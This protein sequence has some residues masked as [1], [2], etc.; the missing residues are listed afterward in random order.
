M[1]FTE[2]GFEFWFIYEIAIPCF[3]LLPH[4]LLAALGPW[5][6]RTP[7]SRPPGQATR[8]ALD[9]IRP[10]S[11]RFPESAPSWRHKSST[12]ALAMLPASHAG[13]TP[14]ATATSSPAPP[15][16]DSP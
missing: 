3:S 8:R 9:Q 10:R 11:P 6:G 16:V 7:A 14:F 5:P 15:P 12:R 1:E 13:R 2:L 4:P